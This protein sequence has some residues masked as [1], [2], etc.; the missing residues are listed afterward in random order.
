MS[1]PAQSSYA[2]IGRT[3][4]MRG[5]R[6]IQIDG[7]VWLKNERGFQI[8]AREIPSVALCELCTSSFTREFPSVNSP[9][10]ALNLLY[11]SSRS[12]FTHLSTLLESNIS[13]PHARVLCC[14]F[15]SRIS[16]IQL[17]YY[18]R[19]ASSWLM[20]R[21]DNSTGNRATFLKWSNGE[22]DQV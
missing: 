9:S 19:L 17:E 15:F 14:F 7:Y 20:E 5:Y 10:F 13:N 11:L 18:S 2:Q 16:T 8:E 4:R 3:V 21:L 22:G 1:I 6:D 12:P